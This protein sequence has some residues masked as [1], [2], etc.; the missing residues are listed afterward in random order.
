MSAD[1]PKPTDTADSDEGL[2]TEPYLSRKRDIRGERSESGTRLG[3]N[4]IKIQIGRLHRNTC[5]TRRLL[6]HCFVVG[7][8]ARDQYEGTNAAAASVGR[9]HAKPCG[10]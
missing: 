6:R 9:Y 4:H 8:D 10:L 7:D 3:K 1:D 5:V 2:L